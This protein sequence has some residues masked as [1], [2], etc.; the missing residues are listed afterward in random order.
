MHWLKRLIKFIF[1][2]RNGPVSFWLGERIEDATWIDVPR[3]RKDQNTAE[4]LEKLNHYEPVYQE[5]FYYR[6]G[7]QELQKLGISQD[8]NAVTYTYIVNYKTGEVY[9]ET[10]QATSASE[11]LY[12]PS[13][14][15]D[16]DGNHQTDEKNFN[17][18]N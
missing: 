7:V 13:T 8:K 18:W 11:L 17:D 4:F 6:V 9:N 14:V 10:K 3:D 2:K 15:Y 12:L 16:K 1:Q 5:D